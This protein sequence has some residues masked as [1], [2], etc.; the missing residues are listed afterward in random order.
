MKLTQET[1]KKM[2][3]EAY[4]K[5]EPSPTT[6]MTQF[7]LDK[8]DPMDHL[9]KIMDEVVDKA[10]EILGTT[11][12]DY[13][14]VEAQLTPLSNE[15]VTAR[16]RDIDGMAQELVERYVEMMKKGQSHPGAL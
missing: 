6:A 10:I 3:A 14:D 7:D 11:E 2:I 4:E 1:L 13:I 15:V 16:L 9:F 5:Y 8:P 12:A